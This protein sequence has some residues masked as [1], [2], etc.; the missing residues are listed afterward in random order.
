MTTNIK[1]LNDKIKSCGMTK[2]LYAK[3]LG[4]NPATIYRKLVAGGE[5]FT[6][7]EMHKTVEVLGLSNEE[8]CQIFL[9]GNSQKC[10]CA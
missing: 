10:E 8:A 1:L 3:A 4:K 6:V 5:T 9:A 7:G 2:E